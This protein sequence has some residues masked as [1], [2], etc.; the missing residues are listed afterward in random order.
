MV[1][2]RRHS[3]S[4]LSVARLQLESRGVP[5]S[6]PDQFEPPSGATDA[7]NALTASA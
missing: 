1:Q 7:R 5:G 6:T 3:E 2:L 4:T